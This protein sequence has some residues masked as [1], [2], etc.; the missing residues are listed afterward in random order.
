MARYEYP[1]AE[2]AI[3]FT[4]LFLV[5]LVWGMSGVISRAMQRYLDRNRK[6]RVTRLVGSTLDV[7]LLLVRLVPRSYAVLV[8]ATLWLA[9]LSQILTDVTLT[10]SLMTALL[11]CLGYLPSVSLLFLLFHDL[12][13]LFRA[14]PVPRHRPLHAL[15]LAL[16][17]LIIQSVATGELSEVLYFWR[18]LLWQRADI[19]RQGRSDYPLQRRC[20]ISLPA[21]QVLPLRLPVD[22]MGIGAAIDTFTG[23]IRSS[24]TDVAQVLGVPPLVDL[25]SNRNS[26]SYLGRASLYTQLQSQLLSLSVC[27]GC[28]CLV[29]RPIRASQLMSFSPCVPGL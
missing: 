1:V 19:F 17:S 8:L 23:T 3:T 27:R 10:P 20:C 26:W 11:W 15:T 4:V 9:M 24:A 16:T 5:L 28:S 12:A 7:V 21:H 13:L 18:C 25:V 22:A 2:H 6:S 14:I 29:N